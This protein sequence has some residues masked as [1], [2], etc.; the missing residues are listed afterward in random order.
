MTVCGVSLFN[1]NCQLKCAG[2]KHI[3]CPKL[4]KNIYSKPNI[5]ISWMSQPLL[6]VIVDAVFPLKKLEHVQ[7]ECKHPSKEMKGYMPWRHLTLGKDFQSLRDT[8]IANKLLSW[9]EV[10]IELDLSVVTIY[11][12]RRYRPAVLTALR[13]WF[14]DPQSAK[15]C[16]VCR[17]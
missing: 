7:W 8:Q 9:L 15:L 12:Q 13:G 5:C 2:M 1:Y 4:S 14:W 10:A 16:P 17:R 6:L 11:L 3:F